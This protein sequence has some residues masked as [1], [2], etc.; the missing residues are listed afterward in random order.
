MC[1]LCVLI[2]M[3]LCV[4]VFPFVCVF[5]RCLLCRPLVRLRLLVIFCHAHRV[6]SVVLSLCVLRFVFVAV[7][8]FVSSVRSSMCS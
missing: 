6:S 3:L 2:V 8:V 1:I 5:L 4:L 7:V